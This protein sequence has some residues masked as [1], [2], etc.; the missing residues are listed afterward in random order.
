M[1]EGFF[2]ADQEPLHQ[3]RWFPSPRKRGEDDLPLTPPVA[4]L[5]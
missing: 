1:V 4:M 2:R 5:T 3:L